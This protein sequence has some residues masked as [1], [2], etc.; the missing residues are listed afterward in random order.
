MHY[1]GNRKYAQV[2]F[3]KYLKKIYRK[4]FSKTFIEI[5]ALS[6][7]SEF[8]EF[9]AHSQIDF[10]FLDIFKMSIFQK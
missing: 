4:E 5:R 2:I 7:K 8:L 6:S 10:S 1:I 3:A 9:F